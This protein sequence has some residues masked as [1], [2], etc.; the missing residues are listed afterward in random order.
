MIRI[1][2]LQHLVPHIAA[3]ETFV[4]KSLPKCIFVPD[5]PPELSGPNR[6]GY[7]VFASGEPRRLLDADHQALR[8]RPIQLN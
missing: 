8:L 1:T 3:A 4:R 2:S 6:C 7:C 5:Y